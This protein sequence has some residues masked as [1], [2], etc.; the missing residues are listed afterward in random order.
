MQKTLQIF[1][2]ESNLLNSDPHSEF[3]LKPVRVEDID[4]IIDLCGAV[5]PGMYSW[6]PNQLTSQLEIFPEGQFA[7]WTKSSTGAPAQLIAMASSLILDYTNYT[8]QAKWSELT[9]WGYLGNHDPENG[10]TLYGVEIMVH[11]DFQGKGVGK[12]IYQAREKLARSHHLTSIRAGARISGYYQQ[13]PVMSAFDYVEKVIQGEFTDPT[14][15]FQ[16][17]RGF[18]VIG[19]TPRYF[20]D[21]ESLNYAAVIEFK[22]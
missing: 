5:Y 16:L 13:A 14:L 20:H 10:K 9:D 2:D 8:L 17:K 6:G 4:A 18:K 12:M 11:P 21:P 7:V 19:I 3:R 15:S 1:R 22:L